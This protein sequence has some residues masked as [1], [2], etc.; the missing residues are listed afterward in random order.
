MRIPHLYETDGTPAERKVIYEHCYLPRRPGYFW[1]IAELDPKEMLAFGYACLDAPEL[2]EWGSID[3]NELLLE[4]GCV[5]DEFWE[6]CRFPEALR[7][8]RDLHGSTATP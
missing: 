7:R 8:V 2:A 3:L 6:P 1:L 4:V 5:K